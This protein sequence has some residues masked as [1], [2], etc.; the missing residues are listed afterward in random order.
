MDLFDEE[1][2]MGAADAR[3]NSQTHCEW[4]AWMQGVA[5]SVCTRSRERTK[6]EKRARA[7]EVRRRRRHASRP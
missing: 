3:G 1:R 2:P 5:E 7:D 6:R 4:D